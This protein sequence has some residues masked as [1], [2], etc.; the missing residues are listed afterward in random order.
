M[1]RYFVDTNVLIGLTF[2]HD[3][4]AVEAERILQTVITRSSRVIL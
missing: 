3:R 2:S 4:W 1:T